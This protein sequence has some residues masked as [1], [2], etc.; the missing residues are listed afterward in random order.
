MNFRIN[1]GMIS[2]MYLF[3]YIYI[4]PVSAEAITGSDSSLLIIDM[5]NAFL[6]LICCIFV[7]AIVSTFRNKKLLELIRSA[8]FFKIKEVISA[9]TLIGS[10]VLLYSITELVYSFKLIEHKVAYRLFKTIFG[11][12]FATGL[13]MQ[14]KVILKYIKQVSSKK[15]VKRRKKVK[16]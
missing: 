1:K 4:T 7:F 13:F 14:Y 10:A 2:L 3:V 9:W 5:M 6:I 15:K 16:G 12:L 11:I 8:H